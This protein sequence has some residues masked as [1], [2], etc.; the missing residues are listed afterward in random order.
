MLLPGCMRYGALK[1]R[2]NFA[3]MLRNHHTMNNGNCQPWI[4]RLAERSILKIKG[5]D[6][7]KFLQGLITN[8]I[9][10]LTGKGC[11]RVMYTMFL[12]AQGRVLYDTLLYA[13]PGQG[14]DF[15]LEC[16]KNAADD[17]IKHVKKYKLR[18]KFEIAD[19]SN[20]FEA[21]AAFI[22]DR[23]IDNAIVNGENE[24]SFIY[25]DPRLSQLG[26]RVL[27]PAGQS[28]LNMPGMEGCN[29]V[30]ESVYKTH[31]YTL[32]I[33]E[34]LQEIPSGNALPL[35]YNLELTH[36]VCFHKGCYIGQELTARTHHTGVIRKRL[37]PL[38]LKDKN[39]QSA[40]S[41]TPYSQLNPQAL[42]KTNTGKSAGKL[43][44]L[45][46]NVGLG[47]LRLKE[48]FNCEYLTASCKDGKE[49][50]LSTY[51]PS[52]WPEDLHY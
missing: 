39:S 1:L 11:T 4:T 8:D 24:S 32:G 44:D 34:G 22:C 41:S 13:L 25:K 3:L 48:V 29:E 23:Q 33:A 15:F 12:N 9:N 2:T 45:H 49:V 40:D 36:G 18:A 10:N 38:V 30:D 43:C 52:W 6:S 26:V 14:D 31:R 46:G 28:P 42:I 47:I 27:A 50:R 5:R 7:R 16:D 21:W 20:D 35:E 17:V 51:R 37:M 19:A